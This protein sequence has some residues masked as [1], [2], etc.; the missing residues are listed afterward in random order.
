M[1]AGG[2]FSAGE[3]MF[4]FIG[5]ERGIAEAVVSFAGTKSILVGLLNMA[6]SRSHSNIYACNCNWIDYSR[7]FS[8]VIRRP[9]V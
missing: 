7:D 6:V 5:I 2:S 9:S 8:D 1:F 4:L 3:E